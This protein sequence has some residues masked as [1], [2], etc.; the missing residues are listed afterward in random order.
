MKPSGY[1]SYRVSPGEP[2]KYHLRKG[3]SAYVRTVCCDCGLVH[4]EEFT[5]RKAYIRV[6]AWRDDRYTRIVRKTRPSR[7]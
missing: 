7:R 1:K 2:I 5:P 3:G 6:R 4:L